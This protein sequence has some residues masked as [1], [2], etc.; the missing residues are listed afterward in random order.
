MN[1]SEALEEIA[2][3]LW[4][5]GDGNGSSP[6]YFDRLS[7]I[8]KTDYRERAEHV[9][10]LAMDSRD[11]YVYGS[12]FQDMTFEEKSREDAERVIQ[13][14]HNAMLALADLGNY[15]PDEV[16]RGTLTRRI[17]IETE[18]EEVPDGE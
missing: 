18:W 4:L 6:E 14:D 8:T 15:P 16:A 11:I 13:D 9:L 17:R 5:W 2:V 10:T 12:R 3:Q 7:D 1:R